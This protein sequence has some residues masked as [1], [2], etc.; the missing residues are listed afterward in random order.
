MFRDVAHLTA[1]SINSDFTPTSRDD[2]QYPIIDSIRPKPFG[3]SIVTSFC[4]KSNYQEWLTT[5][6]DNY[7]S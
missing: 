3:L 6:S 7:K 2:A 4:G 5:Q 1:F